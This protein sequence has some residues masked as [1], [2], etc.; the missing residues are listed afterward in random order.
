MSA[1]SRNGF[2]RCMRS[3]T[4]QWL[5]QH[6]VLQRPC[7][8]SLEIICKTK[9]RKLVKQ[10]NNSPYFLTEQGTLYTIAEIQSGTWL[11][12]TNMHSCNLRNK[13]L[14]K[15]HILKKSGNI[16]FYRFK[17]LYIVVNFPVGW[18]NPTG[19]VRNKSNFTPCKSW[20]KNLFS[21]LLMWIKN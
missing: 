3:Y 5:I 12:F 7:I 18:I 19:P 21:S 11:G 14:A 4:L 13:R 10:I 2:D 6:S 8:S 15:F 16:L 1:N 9:V 20:L 17:P